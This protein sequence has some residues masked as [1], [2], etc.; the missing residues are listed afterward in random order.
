MKVLSLYSQDAV[1][2]VNNH[3]TV[4]HEENLVGVFVVMPNELPLELHD[5]KVIVVHLGDDFWRPMGRKLCELVLQIDWFNFD[6]FCLFTFTARSGTLAS[7][8]ALP[9]RRPRQ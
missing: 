2:E 7:S 5:F 1:P 3:F 4:K 9:Q 8:K 6:F